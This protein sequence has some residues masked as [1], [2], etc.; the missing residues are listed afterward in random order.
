M[1]GVLR[2]DVNTGLVEEKQDKTRVYEI[3]RDET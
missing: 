3:R 1:A 2:D